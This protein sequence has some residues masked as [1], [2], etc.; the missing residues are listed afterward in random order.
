MIIAAVI[1]IMMY[2]M[3]NT[4]FLQEHLINSYAIRNDLWTIIKTEED[5]FDPL[6]VVILASSMHACR[7]QQP[8]HLRL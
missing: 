5:R 1:K 3:M 7:L 6:K 2:L 4:P 8:V